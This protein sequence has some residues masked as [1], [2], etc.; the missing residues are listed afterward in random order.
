MRVLQIQ[1]AASEGE[2][3]QAEVMDEMRMLRQQL[4]LKIRQLMQS[5]NHREALS[6][7]NQVAVM[8]PDDT[9]LQM[10]IQE[11]SG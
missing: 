6:V 8:L 1:K 11:L 4:K 5:G 9:E 2:N 10:L 7:A 3:Q